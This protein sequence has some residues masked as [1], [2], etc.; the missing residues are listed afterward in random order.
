MAN[1]RAFWRTE[2]EQ[3]VERRQSGRIQSWSATYERTRG[4]KLFST[5]CITITWSLTGLI[6]RVFLIGLTK[7]PGC[8]WRRAFRGR[9]RLL[10]LTTSFRE[11]HCAKRLT[12]FGSCR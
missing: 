9:K 10:R 2:T 6:A 8:C 1:L 11:R 4:L 12:A 3:R 5:D 7:E